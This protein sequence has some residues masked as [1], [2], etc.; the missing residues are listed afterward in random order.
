MG[1]CQQAI[2]FPFFFLLSL[3]LS[4]TCELDPDRSMLDIPIQIYSSKGSQRIPSQERS[5]C[6]PL[7]LHPDEFLVSVSFW[8]V[9]RKISGWVLYMYWDGPNSW[10]MNDYANTI[11]LLWL[12]LTFLGIQFKGTFIP[13]GGSWYPKYPS[14]KGPI[15]QYPNF[16]GSISH[17]QRTRIPLSNI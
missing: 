11:I 15:S 7:F 4:R 16:K 8:S 14:F 12:T 13:L 9:L 17:F 10:T 3:S 6:S 1:S 5:F 2:C